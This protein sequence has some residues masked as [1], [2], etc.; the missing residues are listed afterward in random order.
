MT[1]QLQLINIIIIICQGDM[2]R[3]SCSSSGPPRK[4]TQLIQTLC[5]KAINT[6]KWNSL[7]YILLFADI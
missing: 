1:N 5:K 3:P 7:Y 2:F 6:Y 4:Q